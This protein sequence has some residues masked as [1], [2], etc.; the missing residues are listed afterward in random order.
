M[1][2]LAPIALFVYDRPEHAYRTIAALK[3]N[4]LASESDL[5]VFSDGPRGDADVSAIERTRAVLRGISGFRSVC[6]S[7]E[8][9]N[10]GLANSIISGVTRI[11]DIHDQVIVV[12]DDLVTSRYFLRFMNDALN[13][14]RND[15]RVGSVHGYWYPSASR[16]PDTFF[17]RGASCWGWATWTRSWRL[18][19]SDGKK[20]LHELEMR[21]LTHLFDLQG[22]ISYTQM[23]RDQI[24]RRN[25]SWAIRWHASMFLEGKLQLSPGTSLVQNIGFDGSGTHTP[26]TEA[27]QVG[28]AESPV[29]V[30]GIE[31]QESNEARNALAAYYMRTRSAIWR[32]AASRLRRVLVG[33]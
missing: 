6:I 27:Y 32:R 14:Y 29:P 3:D 28:V 2:Q 13:Y 26:K 11:C 16:L 9:R 7:T 5:Y 8:E 25:N 18:F 22:A 19:E 24:A 17:L 10:L 1:P 23:L 30:G 12:E 21:R 31:V 33:R 20:L 15:E 4:E